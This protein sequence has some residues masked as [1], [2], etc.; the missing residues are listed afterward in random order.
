MKKRS[1]A[2]MCILLSVLLFSSVTCASGLPDPAD[3][4]TDVEAPSFRMT[5]VGG[6]VLTSENFGAG[7]NMLLVYGR[8]TCGNTQSFLWNIRDWLDEL[9][10]SGIT[11][12][13]GLYDNPDD[14]EI[15]DFS[16]YFGGVL[17]AKVTNDYYESGMWT[18]LAAVG[19]GTGQVTF[20][21]IF[22]RTA[23]GQLRYYSTGYVDNPLAIVSAAIR[24][25]GV[26]E[27]KKKAEVVLPESLSAVKA[28]AFRNAG[29]V[30]VFCCENVSSVEAYAFAGNSKLQWIYLPPSVTSIDSTVFSGCSGNLV[31]YGSA[32]S[33]A[34]QF[35]EAHHIIFREK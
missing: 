31:I 13:V 2:L 20:P 25:S 22:L 7:K 9:A 28:E 21:V 5:A 11:V 16:E 4:N 34:Q 35:A 27:L 12:L 32:G 8:T 33:A 30:S 18:G 15:T 3:L 6:Q 1:C 19:A 17:C 24:M 10:E 29:V 26:S 23:G 14:D